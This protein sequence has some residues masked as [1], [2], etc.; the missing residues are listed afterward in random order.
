[1]E[2]GLERGM[3]AAIAVGVLLAVILGVDLPG[4]KVE[5]ST[6]IVADGSNPVLTVANFVLIRKFILSQGKRLTYCNMFSD[7]PYWPFPGFNSYL[8][9]PD[10]RNINCEI[11][12]SEFNTLV[13][14]VTAPHTKY[15]NVILDEDGKELR[16]RQ[17][18]SKPDP[19][20]LI[21]EATEFFRRA[22]TE[23]EKQTRREEPGKQ[24]PAA[25][26]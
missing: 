15:W 24:D 18:Y 6:A 2:V 8:N 26:K 20:V 19:Q 4:A 13:I 11:G 21:Q 17:Y 7:N 25:G 22:L 23:I 14:Q 12:R 3:N 16:V 1:M 5:F 10:Q 9:P